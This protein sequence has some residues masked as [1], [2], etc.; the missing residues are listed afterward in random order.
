[1]EPKL[2]FI[3][4]VTVIHMFSVAWVM[5]VN[6]VDVILLI[7]WQYAFVQIMIYILTQCLF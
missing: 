2:L 7:L 3:C 4:A 5:N 6:H 1:M